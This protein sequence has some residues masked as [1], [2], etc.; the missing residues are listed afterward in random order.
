LR[1]LDTPAQ[2]AQQTRL[3]VLRL[4]VLAEHR[5]LKTQ[6][7]WLPNLEKIR[8]YAAPLASGRSIEDQLID[9]VGARAFYSLDEIPRDADSFEAQRL[10]GRKHIL[11]A[12]QEVTKL[13]QALFE[14]YHELRLALESAGKRPPTWQYAIDDL[15]DQLGALLPES[16]LTTTPWQWLQHAPRYL[17]G[18]T[19]RLK[20]ITSSGIPRDRQAHDQIASRW[21]AFKERAA[22]HNQH[23]IDDPELAIFRWMVEELRVSL[24]AQ[25]LGTSIPVSPQRLDK[26][27]SKVQI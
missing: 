1:L 16:F 9:L 12:V 19:L 5:E 25:E 7:R 8:L 23:G 24:F 2:A 6:V 13:V 3:G 15:R 10:I 26:Q 11:P 22:E 14:A 4:F 18:M 27:W 21:Q 17:K 20:K